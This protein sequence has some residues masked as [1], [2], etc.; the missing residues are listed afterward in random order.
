MPR[1]TS[2]KNQDKAV[3]WLRDSN[4][5]GRLAAYH[6]WHRVQ[7]VPSQ[8]LSSRLKGWKTGRVHH[9]LSELERKYFLV[10][11]WSPLVID[12]REQFPLLPLDETLAIAEACGFKHPTAPGTANFHV[13]TSDFVITVQSQG[14]LLEVVRS[15]KYAAD[16]QSE[17][18]LEK[19]EIER[20]YW[21]QRRIDWGIVTEREIPETLVH[22]VEWVHPWHDFNELPVLVQTNLERIFKAFQ[23]SL[24]DSG[25]TLN[26]ICHETDDRFGLPHGSTLT[27]FRHLLAVGR[28]RLEMNQAP[29]VAAK[30]DSF[31]IEFG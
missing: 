18:T 13:L 20:R 30:N 4:S 2:A 14:D 29:V 5:H 27:A 9:F 17:R 10:L 26:E 24:V 28:I 15:T 23:M 22:N 19:L 11:E 21:A 8:G 12:I 3:D 31:R 7:D 16:L 25:L 1:R 6:P